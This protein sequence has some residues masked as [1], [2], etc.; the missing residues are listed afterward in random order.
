MGEVFAGV[1]FVAGKNTSLLVV[2]NASQYNLNLGF[3]HFTR[4]KLAGLLVFRRWVKYFEV[5]TM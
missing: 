2:K 4:F 1:A 5:T 3:H